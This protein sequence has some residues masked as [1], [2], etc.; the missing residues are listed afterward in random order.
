MSKL[1][2]VHIAK[3]GGISLRRLLRASPEVNSFDC[4]HH[5]VLLRFRGGKQVE[6]L[7]VDPAS[8]TGYD[9]AVITA[10]HPLDRLHSCYRYF[11]AGGLNGRGKGHFPGDEAVQSFLKEIAPTLE[12]CCRFLPQVASR[13]PHFQPACHWLEALPNPMADVVVTIRQESMQSDLRRYWSTMGLSQPVERLE[14]RNR[15]VPVS[16]HVWQRSSRDFAERFYQLDYQRF[17]YG[18]SLSSV[19]QLIQ[20]WDQPD[21]PEPV[22]VLMQNVRDL[23]PDWEYQCFDRQ[24]AADEL[25]ALYGNDLREAFLDI[26]LPAMQ[27][28]VFRMAYLLRHGGVWIDAATRL[29]S[30]VERWLPMGH[31]LVLLRRQQQTYPE[32]ATGFIY[33]SAGHP[34]LARAWDRISAYLLLRSGTKVYRHFGPGILR[35][36]MRE[37][38]QLASMVQVLPEQDV[39]M[40]LSF[41]SS[42]CV[43]GPAQHWSSRQTEESFYFSDG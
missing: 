34:L 3:T 40:S 39:L 20:Y 23:H 26:R 11:L 41:G 43:L 24:R 4:L 17:G 33:A 42:G 15:S 16:E 37:Q 12:D 8:L 31:P 13:I 10:R 35:D 9:I 2:L 19:R 6:R 28:D 29:H 14:H 1:L 18:S 22:K 7:R 5:N 38:P 36:L 30:S 25:G 21:P 32:V 27:A